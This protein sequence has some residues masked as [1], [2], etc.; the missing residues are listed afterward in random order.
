[1][2][3]SIALVEVTVYTS[4]PETLSSCLF[5]FMTTLL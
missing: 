3:N 4:K 2:E 5:L 1:M